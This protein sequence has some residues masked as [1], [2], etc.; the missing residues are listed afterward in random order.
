MRAVWER[1]VKTDKSTGIDA[2]LTFPDPA[3]R[4]EGTVEG[5]WGKKKV[6]EAKESQQQEATGLHHDTSKKISQIFFEVPASHNVGCASRRVRISWGVDAP[7][8]EVQC[9]SL[10]QARANGENEC[11]AMTR[12]STERG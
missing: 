4:E 11:E 8:N 10:L 2:R 6:L 12:T 1:F 9:M 5:F 7:L 3:G